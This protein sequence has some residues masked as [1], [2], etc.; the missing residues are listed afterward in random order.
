[1]Y[2]KLTETQLSR[3]NFVTEQTTFSWQGRLAAKQPSEPPRLLCVPSH[4]GDVPGAE[5]KTTGRNGPET[6]LQTIWN[7]CLMKHYSQLCSELL[8]NTHGMR[9]S[10][11]QKHSIN[12][13]S[14]CHCSL[15]S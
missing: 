2:A 10:S 5:T 4:V 7:V 6:A 14:A 12:L 1:M 15:A 8:Q 13:F 11:T 3:T 9:G